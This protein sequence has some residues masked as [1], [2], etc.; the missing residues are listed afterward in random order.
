MEGDEPPEWELFDCEAD[1]LELFNVADDP[2]Y[3]DVFAQ[4]VRDLDAKMAEIGDIPQH[5][6]EAALRGRRARR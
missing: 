4:M 3:A 5:D 2:A 6:S 1:P